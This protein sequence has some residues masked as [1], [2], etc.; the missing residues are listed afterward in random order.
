MF[1]NPWFISISQA[2]SIRL[3]SN[4]SHVLQMEVDFNFHIKELQQVNDEPI[5]TETVK[6]LITHTLHLKQ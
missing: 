2:P 6:K 4:A 1:D 5:Q 3:L